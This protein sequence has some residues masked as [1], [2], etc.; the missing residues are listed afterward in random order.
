M[1]KNQADASQVRALAL[2]LKIL[3]HLGKHLHIVNLMGANTVH[4]GKGKETVKMGHEVKR[5][6]LKCISERNPGQINCYNY[7]SELKLHFKCDNTL[8]ILNQWV[9]IATRTAMTEIDILKWN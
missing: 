9:P 1:C 7:V 6:W 5:E 8:K 2:E 3:N 4:I